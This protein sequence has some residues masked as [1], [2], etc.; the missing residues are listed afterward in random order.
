MEMLWGWK[1]ME[2]IAGE[3]V[4][5]TPSLDT[6]FNKLMEEDGWMDRWILSIQELCS[7]ICVCDG[8]WENALNV[9][10]KNLIAI[11]LIVQKSFK[12]NTFTLCCC[13]HNHSVFC[14]LSILVY[15]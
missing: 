3:K 11:G 9:S 15:M 8:D 2:S 1:M 10:I 12:L 13:I 7:G 14:D 5:E 4:S 6:T